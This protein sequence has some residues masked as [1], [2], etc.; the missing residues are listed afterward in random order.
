VKHRIALTVAQLQ[1]NDIAKKV[2]Q[3]LGEYGKT[4]SGL[5]GELSACQILN[6]KWQPADGYD[7][8]SS[9]GQKVQ[10]KTRKSWSTK[11]V[12]PLGRLGKFGRKAGYLFQR[13]LLVELN[14]NFDVS[15]IWE[16]SKDK[17]AELEHKE[18]GR[19]LHV[20]TYRKHSKL[21]YRVSD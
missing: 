10:V 19:G 8:I 9:D 2:A 15:E 17:I 6:L 21:V 20:H 16:M 1:L 14:E 5:I 12:N 11:T 7:A 18:R 4:L 3:E 13:G